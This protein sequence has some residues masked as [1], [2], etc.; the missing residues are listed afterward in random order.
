M[1]I[2]K[3]QTISLTGE[4][5]VYKT[6]ATKLPL[7]VMDCAILRFK[8][9]KM[10]EVLCAATNRKVNWEKLNSK[11]KWM[12]VIMKKLLWPVLLAGTWFLSSMRVSGKLWRAGNGK[13]DIIGKPQ[14]LSAPSWG[15]E[16]KELLCL[17]AVWSL[18][19]QQPAG[20]SRD[21]LS[22]II[23]TH[24]LKDKIFSI[25]TLPC[26]REEQKCETEHGVRRRDERRRR[27]ADT[28]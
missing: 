8:F 28:L 9:C 2:P 17:D 15:Y 21:E 20:H 22:Q 5:N 12:N 3:C 19:R 16:N 26:K 18:T 27:R 10:C 23:L 11:H 4:K 25:S 24:C 1:Y 14:W 7:S 13:S 6:A